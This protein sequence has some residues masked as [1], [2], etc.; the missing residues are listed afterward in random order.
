[1]N[2]F[3]K[4]KEAKEKEAKRQKENDKKIRVFRMSDAEYQ[5]VKQ[6]AQKVGIGVTIFTRITVLEEAKKI[7]EEKK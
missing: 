2:K 7:L 6:A 4:Y 5:T 1:M 3:D